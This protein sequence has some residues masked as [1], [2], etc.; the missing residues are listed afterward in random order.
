MPRGLSLLLVVHG[1]VTFAAG[2]VLSAAPGLIPSVV[3]IRWDPHSNLVAYLLAGAEFGFAALSLGG[4]RVRDRRA[5][6]VIVG[7]C[8]A[9]HAS[10]GALEIVAYSQG[11][12]VAILANVVAR[13][14]ICALFA[15][16]SL[17][18]RGSGFAS[19]PASPHSSRDQI[20]SWVSLS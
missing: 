6:Q 17:R 1:L 13:V 16:F 3:G 15:F 8:I 7:S 10:S 20:F 4:S 9:F 11:V 5:L 19:I 12:G 2:V 18:L 14:V